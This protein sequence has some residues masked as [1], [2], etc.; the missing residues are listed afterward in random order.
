MFT[1]FLTSLNTFTLSLNRPIYRVSN[2]MQ[3][4][5]D[6]LRESLEFTIPK[7][8]FRNFLSFYPYCSPNVI[9][10]LV[11]RTSSLILKLSKTKQSKNV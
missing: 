1:F 10:N 5:K 2:L 3:Q 8:A 4:K 7:A 9:V 11:R 6:I